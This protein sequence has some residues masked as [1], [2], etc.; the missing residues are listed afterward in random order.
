MELYN[1]DQMF[2]SEQIQR[3]MKEIEDAQKKSHNFGGK[4]GTTIELQK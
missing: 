1:E 3:K 4:F 2:H